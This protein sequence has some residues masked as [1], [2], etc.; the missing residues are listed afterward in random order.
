V[1]SEIEKASFGS[2]DLELA[3]ALE[4]LTLPCNGLMPRRM[5][6]GKHFREGQVLIVERRNRK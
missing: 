6:S 1:Y 2:N 3:G 4:S 5:R